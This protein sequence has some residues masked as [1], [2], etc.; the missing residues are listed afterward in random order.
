[1]YDGH[2]DDD[3]DDDDDDNDFNDHNLI[4]KNHE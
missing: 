4:W 2:I 1:M 3:D